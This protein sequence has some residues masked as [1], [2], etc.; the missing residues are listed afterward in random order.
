MKRR[1]FLSRSALVTAGTMLIPNF[2][3]AFEKQ[4]LNTLGLSNKK[5]VIIQ[6]SGGNDGLNTVIPFRNDIYYKV[7]PKLAIESQHVLQLSDELGF[8]PALT[9]MKQLYDDGLLTILNSV[10]YPNPDRSHFRSMDIW[11]TAS[12]S[13]EFL[14]T[15]WI[16]RYLDEACGGSCSQPYNAIEV[17]DTLSLA[18]KGDRL[19][20]LAVSNP[21]KLYQ[22]THNKIITDINSAQHTEADHEQVSYLYKTLGETVS[23]AAYIYDKSKIYKTKATYPPTELGRKLKTIAELILS[24]VETNIFYVSIS[25]FD[26]HVNQKIRQGQLLKQYSEAMSTFIQDLKQN[27]QLNE[28]LVMTF[29]EFG[30]RVAQNGSGGTDHGTANNVFL[31]GGKLQK[32][33]LFNESPNLQNLDEGDLKYQID[34]RSIYATLLKDW[35]GID[36]KMIISNSAGHLKLV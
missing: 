2:L 12:G 28:S 29:S 1:D 34:F 8:N 22:L 4:H 35:L 10:G 27:N 6:L 3:K 26:T 36:D 16:G 30:R 19:K 5:L 33:G 32:P 13:D 23:S 21:Q 11:Q 24:G 31:I 14:G 7:R 9:G 25:G 17:D 20:G 15:G 18:M